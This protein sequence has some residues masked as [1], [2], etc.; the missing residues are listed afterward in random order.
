MLAL[1][2]F[3]ALTIFTL[4][5]FSG[6]IGKEGSEVSASTKLASTT[7]LPP[8]SVASSAAPVSTI[9]A[10][11]PAG[12]GYDRCSTAEGL[13]GICRWGRCYAL[14]AC[15]LANSGK[16]EDMNGHDCVAYGLGTF[17]AGK[18]CSMGA[19]GNAAESSSS[20][21]TTQVSQ[22]ASTTMPD[23]YRPNNRAVLLDNLTNIGFAA[24]YANY[25]F[26]IGQFKYA[27]D[28]SIIG[29]VIHVARPDGTFVDV[30]VIK[31]SADAV[32]DKK[33]AIRFS[34][35]HAKEVSGV[36][37]GAIYVW[38]VDNASVVVPNESSA[39]MRTGWIKIQSALNITYMEDGAFNA[40]FVNNA[41]ADVKIDGVE[42]NETET[43]MKC[44][45]ILVKGIQ[46]STAYPVTVKYGERFDISAD[47]PP[48]DYDSGYFLQIAISYKALMED[49]AVKHKET[50][51]MSGRVKPYDEH[52]TP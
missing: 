15:C 43:V 39:A 17:V 46:A 2:R 37:T 12:V 23:P 14:G 26:S 10:S 52:Y 13:A 28:R 25:S 29:A 1:Q 27:S 8:T 31:D 20:T 48:K 36:Q 19:C 16:C 41:G 32:L 11:C 44:S 45:N 38:E 7:S 18:S 35:T 42:L 34:P 33:L 40:A 24:S 9:F 6:C 4:L 5:I 47:C 3:S 22:A 21:T 51:R 50:G 49:G 30:V